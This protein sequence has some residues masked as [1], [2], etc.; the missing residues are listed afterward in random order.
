MK[1]GAW[2]A[3]GAVPGCTAQTPRAGQI[4][5]WQ[6]VQRRAVPNL[7]RR[8][9]SDKSARPR[10]SRSTPRRCR[11]FIIVHSKQIVRAIL[12]AS[13]GRHAR[14]IRRHDTMSKHQHRRDR[15]P[16][17]HRAVKSRAWSPYWRRHKRA[18]I[19]RIGAI[20]AA[21]LLGLFSFQEPLHV[22]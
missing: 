3:S 11:S 2:G 16:A 14:L 18:K 7:N 21:P 13:R 4:S 19:R 22:S 1:L 5:S 9:P 6:C 17:V 15:R 20:L 12:T 8:S 10:S